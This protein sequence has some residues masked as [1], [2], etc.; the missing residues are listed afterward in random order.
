MNTKQFRRVFGAVV[1]IVELDKRQVFQDDPGQGTPSMVYM[2]HC[3][4]KGIIDSG[5]FNCAIQTGE[6]SDEGR[7][8]TQPMSDWLQ[9][10]ET[11]V[12][13]FLSGKETV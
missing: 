13:A 5:T 3:S 10:L 6:L 8:L 12:E 7:R 11:E 9:S 2:K 1:L 4:G